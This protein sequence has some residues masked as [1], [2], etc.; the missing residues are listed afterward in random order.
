MSDHELLDAIS[1]MMENRLK[2]EQMLSMS[3]M[4]DNKL[5]PINDRLKRI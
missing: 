2:P 3:D 5:K 1:D 4:M